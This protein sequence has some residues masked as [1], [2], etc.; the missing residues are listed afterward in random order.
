DPL[1]AGDTAWYS[2][3]AYDP[4]TPS[5]WRRHLPW[6]TYASAAPTGGLRVYGDYVAVDAAPELSA[7][8]AYSESGNRS[9]QYVTSSVRE[10]VR[11]G[12]G[13]EAYFTRVTGDFTDSRQLVGVGPV[14]SHLWALDADYYGPWEYG[15]AILMDGSLAAISWGPGRSRWVRAVTA[16]GSVLWTTQLDP[17]RF[18]RRDYLAVASSGAV[19]VLGVR[20]GYGVTLYHLSGDGVLR[21]KHTWWDEGGVYPLAVA[22]VDDTTAVVAAHFPGVGLD[23]LF[24]VSGNG[25]VLWAWGSSVTYS[26]PRDSRPPLVIGDDAAFLATHG[27]NSGTVTAVALADGSLQWQVLETSLRDDDRFKPSALVANGRL[28]TASGHLIISRDAATGG[29]LWRHACA[30]EVQDLLITASG[31]LI[32]ASSEGDLAGYLEALDVGAGPADT[33]W[34]MNYADA[35]R[36]SRVRQQ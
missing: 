10:P 13:G 29:E 16:S 14:G 24:A 33:P 15:P 30:A 36:T 17:A 1:G 20:F 35:A 7:V 28:I 5:L 27:W 26:A 21:W 8:S 18:S 6:A 32:A 4:I 11:L 31:L 22:L 2:T 23:S 19:Y 12:S 3:R 9:W 25:E 34:P